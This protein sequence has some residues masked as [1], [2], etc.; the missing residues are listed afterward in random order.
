VEREGEREREQ[1]INGVR[2]GAL[3][4]DGNGVHQ[5]WLLVKNGH[6]S[7]FSNAHQ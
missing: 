5:K 2:D 6:P 7:I 3:D 4:R 1:Q